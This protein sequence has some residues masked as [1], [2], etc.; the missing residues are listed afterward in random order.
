MKFILNRF[1]HRYIWALQSSFM[2]PEHHE[3]GVPSSTGD[4]DSSG[5]WGGCPTSMRNV[6]K[7]G[8]RE[9][10]LSFMRVGHLVGWEW[11]HCFCQNLFFLFPSSGPYVIQ[12]FTSAVLTNKNHLYGEGFNPKQKKAKKIRWRGQGGVQNNLVCLGI[13]NRP[14]LFELSIPP[15]CV[16]LGQFC[17]S[18]P[19]PLTRPKRLYA[20]PCLN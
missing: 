13:I 7:E 15:M 20:N 3:K 4:L 14:G 9:S 2:H 17:N 5:R 11:N 12:S 16:E 19:D 8:R 6:W 18:W 1:H 10:C